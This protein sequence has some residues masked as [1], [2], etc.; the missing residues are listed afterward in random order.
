MQ[1]IST[2]SIIDAKTEIEKRVVNYLQSNGLTNRDMDNDHLSYGMGKEFDYCLWVEGAFD[3]IRIELRYVGH[4]P[5]RI[6]RRE[7]MALDERIATVNLTRDYPEQA[8]QDMLNNSTLD[9]IFV[10][11][12]GQLQQTC[13]YEYMRYKMRNMA[14]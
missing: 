3:N 5:E 2:N 7:L 14:F 6:V 13:M 4:K 8:Y 9:T 11:I 1:N 12:D 10:M